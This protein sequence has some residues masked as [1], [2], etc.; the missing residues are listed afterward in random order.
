MR[1]NVN[2]NNQFDSCGSNIW[3]NHD[4]ETLI[5]MPDS[6]SESS[7]PSFDIENIFL[8][9]PF[10]QLNNF[11]AA[12]NVSFFSSSSLF[13]NLYF[14]KKNQRYV[15][16]FLEKDQT[17]FS[18]DYFGLYFDSININNFCD[19]FIFVLDNDVLCSQS[20]NFMV[21]AKTTSE[22]SSSLVDLWVDIT[23]KM[24]LK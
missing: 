24:R 2:N 20:G 7:L 12:N 5:V 11:A 6:F 21:V 19:D 3:Y 10:N 17:E 4:I 16:S 15:F 14:A 13:N 18:Y 23:A 1:S 8:T 22:I 9:Q